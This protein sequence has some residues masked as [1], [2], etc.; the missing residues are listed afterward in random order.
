M[1]NLELVPG[2]RH[3]CRFTVLGGRR[4][5]IFRSFPKRKTSK[6]HECRA[7]GRSWDKL[8]LKYLF[9][10]CIALWPAIGFAQSY[11]INWFTI[12]GGGGTTTDRVYWVSGTVGQPEAGGPLTNGQYSV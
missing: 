1:K 3:S 10:V 7:P 8:Y 5:P 11:S 6:R 2:A 4:P 9:L 12:D